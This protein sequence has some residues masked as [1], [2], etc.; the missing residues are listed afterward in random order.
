MTME[1]RAG[2]EYPINPTNSEDD[3]NHPRYPEYRNWRNAMTR[4]LVAA[5]S[6][7]NWLA[8]TI[9][10]EQRQLD[11]RHPR[12][13]EYCQWLRENVNCPKPTQPY[14]TFREWLDN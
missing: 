4:Q 5:N 13:M 12:H 7:R 6:F 8:Q 11:L 9:E 2:C 10:D 14:K 3:T 1:L